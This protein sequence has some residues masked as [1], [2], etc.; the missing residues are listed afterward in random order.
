[1]DNFD[2]RSAA[3]APR[4]V[5]TSAASLASLLRLFRVGVTAG[6]LVWTCG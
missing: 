4:S 3:T 6:M 2:L 5:A 1:M